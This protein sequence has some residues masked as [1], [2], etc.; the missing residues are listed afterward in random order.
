MDELPADTV[1]IEPPPAEATDVP[2]TLTVPA[3]EYG[4]NPDDYKGDDK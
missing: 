1:T 2:D 4:I 3:D